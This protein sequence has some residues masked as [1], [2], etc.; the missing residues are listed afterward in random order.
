VAMATNRFRVPLE[1]LERSAHVPVEDQVEEQDVTPPTP[2]AV[3]QEERRRQQILR[4]GV[5]GL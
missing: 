4:T 5:P 3:S 2:D 1:D